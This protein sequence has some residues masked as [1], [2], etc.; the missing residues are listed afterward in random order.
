MSISRFFRI[1]TSGCPSWYSYFKKIQFLF[2]LNKIFLFQKNFS[3]QLAPIKS[4]IEFKFSFQITRE[5][6]NAIRSII[7]AV[8]FN[9]H[10]CCFNINADQIQTNHETIQIV[11]CPSDA[12]RF[13]CWDYAHWICILLVWGK[14][15]SGF[16]HLPLAKSKAANF[17]RYNNSARPNLQ[18]VHRHH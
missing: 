11:R 10:A 13:Q 7:R 5:T 12:P 3:L 18:S 8:C 15:L 14:Y 2:Q 6:K 1:N 17:W 16:L 4:K 9:I